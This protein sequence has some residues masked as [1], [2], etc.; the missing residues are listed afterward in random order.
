MGM[1]TT[2]LRP[3][4]LLR[5]M[6]AL[7]ALGLLAGCGKARTSPPVPDASRTEELAS[8]RIAVTVTATPGAVSL[9]KPLILTLTLS[10]PE[11]VTATW[12]DLADRF[13]GFELS[14]VYETGAQTENGRSRRDLRVR[15][16]PLPAPEYRL[17]PLAIL[18]RDSASDSDKPE[19]IRTRPLVF[20]ASARTSPAELSPPAPPVPIPL[21]AR[22][23]AL[24]LLAVA[25]AVGILYLAYRLYQRL[26]RA[27]R[28]RQMSPRQRALL[29]LEEL[30]SRH[31]IEQ[32]L[33][34][35]FYFELTAVVRRYI[36]R[37]HGIRAPEQ[38]T[39]EFLTSAGANARF[40]R[41][42]LDKLQ[43]FLTAADWVKFANFKPGP[44]AGTRALESARQYVATDPPE[45][46]EKS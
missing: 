21:S 29:E 28:L 26:R 37:R 19:W 38:T 23:I 17:K 44:E 43:E 12:P 8:G 32:N 9:E 22:E 41:A 30:A 31:L 10:T 25:A 13:E 7:F 39:E 27:I 6:P 35:D 5:I 4:R 46:K 42:T 1:L 11:S 34:K 16:T 40:Q 20:A 36:E 24:L 33:L 15:L 45:L 3:G 14:D 18:F 2:P